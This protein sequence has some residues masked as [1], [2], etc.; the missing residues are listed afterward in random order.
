MRC[1]ASLLLFACLA[2]L[3][4]VPAHAERRVAL[5]IGNGDYKEKYF[6]RLENPVNDARDI[7]AA[8]KS[9]NF[10]VTLKVNSSKRDIEDAIRILGT[11]LKRGGVGLF[12]FA[13]HGMQYQNSNFL[14]PVRANI[15]SN[16]DLEYEAVNAERVLT[17][18]S[19]ADNGFN[20]IIL[21][22]CRANSDFPA[23][24]R[25][26]AGGLAEMRAL[27]GSLIA[28][29]TAPGSYAADGQGKNGT[30]TESLLKRMR[31]PGLPVELMFK[32][33]RTDVAKATGSQQIPWEHSSLIGDFSFNPAAPQAS[34]AV[35]PAAPAPPVLPAP[36]PLPTPVAPAPQ[37]APKVV[38]Q[39][40]EAPVKAPQKAS[41]GRRVIASQA[42]LREK[43]YAESNVLE[44]IDAGDILTLEGTPDGD[45]WVYLTHEKSG[46]RGYLQRGIDYKE[47]R[48][49]SF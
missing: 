18:M 8:L 4:A 40:M 15:Q 39:P 9:F 10:E 29:A 41:A 1:L 44:V 49:G 30:Y 42:T 22:A 17:E 48:N 19:V 14:I 31:T 33:V 27:T 32:K 12:Y 37:A 36:A 13:G 43:A 20:I 7:A 28:Y 45:G 47:V 46:K 38:K 6:G 25:S 35:I 5:V 23:S 24:K 21:D 26:G 16:A 34:L 3:S 11:Q 2:L